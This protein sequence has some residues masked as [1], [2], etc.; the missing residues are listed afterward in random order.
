MNLHFRIGMLC[1]LCLALAGSADACRFWGLVGDGY[2]PD[3]IADQL[4]DGSVTS[5]R[6]LAVTYDDGWGIAYVPPA[7]TQLPLNMPIFRRGGPAADDPGEPEFGLAVD[8][9]TLIR[10]PVALA[11]IRR[12]S[13]SPCGIPDPHPFRHEGLLFAHH[14]TI[15]DSILVDLLTRDD[16]NYLVN[17][18]PDYIGEMIDSELYFLYLLKYGHQHPELT[19]PEALRCAVSE[20]ANLTSSRLSFVLAA[21]DT[22]FALRHARSDDADPVRYFPDASGASPFWI[23][24]SQALG[25]QTAN[26]G[27]IPAMTLAVLV[28]GEPPLFLPT[29]AN[30]G[31]EVPGD[32]AAL[33]VG[34][35]RPNPAARSIEIPLSVPSGGVTV[36]FEVWDA[37]GRLIWKDGPRQID[38]GESELLW[39]TADRRGRQVPAGTYFCTVSA[40]TVVS[41]QPITVVR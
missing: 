27:T 11:H 2:P 40:G 15:S 36:R 33:T 14:G 20:L 4:R 9:M 34:R 23:A 13:T 3:T 7:T 41:R 29:Y 21:G 24:A 39:Q 18:P 16:P 37:Q 32:G 10:P 5:L 38:A 6:K 30:A 28:P 8:E 12:C 31:I 26:W 35:A 19:R 25:S 22:L 17:H 1:F